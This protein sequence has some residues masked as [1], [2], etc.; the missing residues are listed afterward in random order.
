MTDPGPIYTKLTPAMQSPESP[1]EGVTVRV[2]VAVGETVDLLHPPFF[3]AGV[4]I[5]MERGVSAK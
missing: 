2:A 5:W 3:L 4:S 1:H